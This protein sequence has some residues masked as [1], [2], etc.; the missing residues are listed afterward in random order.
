VVGVIL[1]VPAGV[2]LAITLVNLASWRR[3][4]ASGAPGPVSA[5]VPAR[6]E[7]ATIERCV[8]ALLAQE[9]VAQV[10]VYDDGSTDRTPEILARLAQEDP[11]LEVVRGDGLP[12]GW[13]GKPHACHQLARHARH[14]RLLFVD[15]DTT[16]LPGGVAAL[17]SVDADV[18]SAFPRQLVGSLG[19]ALVLP[20]LHLTYLSWLPLELVRRVRDPR[21]LAANGQVLS[22]SR[23]AYD[24][25]GG[26]A[27]VRNEVV[28]DM[29]LCRA[30]KVAGRT[31]AFVDGFGVAE[32]RMYASFLEAVD[33]FSKNLFEGLGSVVALAGVLALYLAAFVVPWVAAPL[34]A[35]AWLGVAANLAQRALIAARFRLPVASVWGHLPSAL[36]FVGVGLRSWFWSRSNRIAWRGRTYAA[37]AVRG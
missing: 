14:E 23:A 3:P 22:I 7:E 20:L 37:R 16:V 18:V 28:D 24:A 25:I 30:A 32:C 4:V 8:R 34:V 35:G 15:S 9:P 10:V 6:D 1:S 33:G 11:R 36:I 2:A 31:V 29:A 17:G 12:A 21:V 13:V 19:E 5:L 26:F 27:A